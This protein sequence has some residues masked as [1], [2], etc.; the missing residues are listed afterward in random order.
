MINKILKLL[1]DN[2]T[3]SDYEIN[4]TKT[5]AVQLFYVLNKLETNR[6]TNN[7]D[8]SVTLYVD[9]YNFRGSCSFVVNA[10]D[11]ELSLT[12]KISEAITTAK[13]IN[14]KYFSLVKPVEQPLAKI[15]SISNFNLSQ[16][17]TKCMDAIVEA[18]HFKDVWINSTEIFVTNKETRF[19]NSLGVDL[20]YS[21]TTLEVELIPTAKNSKGEEFELYLDV[22]QLDEDYSRVKS[23]VEDILRSAKYRAEAVPYDN[24]TMPVKVVAYGDDMLTTCFGTL[25]N[26]LSYA[27]VLMQGNH[28]KKGTEIVPY[29]LGITLKPTISGV[30]SS[31]P[32]DESGVVLLETPLVKEGKVINYFG[33]N[34]YGQYLGEKVTGNFGA[35]E[36]DVASSRRI[37]EP[38][39]PYMELL[40]FSSPQMDEGSGYFGGEVR[41][42]LY[43]GIDGKVTPVTGLSLSG[44]LYKAI[45][46]AYFSTN[47]KIYKNLKGP[48]KIFITDFSL[49]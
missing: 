19:I 39:L 47:D 42:A 31:K 11:D 12:Q 48:E 44:N 22:V 34:R 37:S 8:I 13:S 35:Y 15:S 32:F 14:N 46:S 49:N 41:L 23:A 4:V 21:K 40:N 33:G 16:I 36:V 7:S 26:D 43:H 25:K 17:A 20:S 9:H 5:Q 18:D 30:S 45:K 2:K 10:A 1:N 38:N 28:Y 29:N 3:I 6:Y 27:N 24:K